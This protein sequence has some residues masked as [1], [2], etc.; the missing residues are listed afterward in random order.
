MCDVYIL[1]ILGSSYNKSITP[2]VNP[3]SEYNYLKYYNIDCN[4]LSTGQTSNKKLLVKTK[5]NV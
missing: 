1:N 3:S 5:I 2:I 4:T